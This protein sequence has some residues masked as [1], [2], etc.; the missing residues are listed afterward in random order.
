MM[1]DAYLDIDDLPVTVGTLKTQGDI[2]PVGADQPMQRFIEQSGTRTVLS[3]QSAE[4]DTAID[5]ETGETIS[6]GLN[7]GIGQPFADYIRDGLYNAGFTMPP[8]IFGDPIA[9]DNPLPYWSTGGT[10]TANYTITLNTSAATANFIR[11]NFP[12]GWTTADEQVFI[13]QIIPVNGSEY[14][15]EVMT[16]LIY[17][18]YTQAAASNATYRWS[19]QYL[20]ETGALTGTAYEVSQNLS[21]TGT[22]GTYGDTWDISKVIPA[23]AR[24]ARLR[25]GMGAG[26]VLTDIKVDIHQ[27]R[28][29]RS[30]TQTLI[31]T[32]PSYATTR[33]AA[34]ELNDTGALIKKLP[35]SFGTQEFTM[36]PAA[37]VQLSWHLNNIPTGA[38]TRMR[39]GEAANTGV[40][41]R[42]VMPWS[43]FVVG[44]SYQLS[45]AF[46]GG[47]LN[48]AIYKNDSLE[49]DWN[50]VGQWDVGGG[51]NI[52]ADLRGYA[53]RTYGLVTGSFVAGDYLDLRMVAS[54]GFGPT[55][56]DAFVVLWVAL[57][58]NGDPIF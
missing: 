19:F 34:L 41:N 1:G 24:F 58:Y 7:T 52:T 8:P 36:P 13:E 39:Y 5:P 18:T 16:P 32:N 57:I 26:T 48:P 9:P 47:G 51:A 27:V 3:T 6:A 30:V 40:N 33:S 10:V 31:R 44:M 49:L 38:T 2:Y 22:L 50:D 56:M 14:A 20:T 28:I 55:T 12:D 21:D 45:E 54:A 46:S 29:R 42:V 25:I 11:F 43:G 35:T 23:D 37:L 53:K 17:A 15:Q 4:G